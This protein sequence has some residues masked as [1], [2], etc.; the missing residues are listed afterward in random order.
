VSRT[1]DRKRWMISTDDDGNVV[2]IHRHSDSYVA[3]SYSGPMRAQIM[4]EVD[5][6]RQALC[7]V[8]Y[9]HTVI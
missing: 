4:T 6:T 8:C 9:T 5:G 7:P 1:V 2:A 3:D